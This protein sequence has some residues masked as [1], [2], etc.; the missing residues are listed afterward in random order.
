VWFLTEPG[1]LTSERDAIERLAT[2]VEWL[3]D[4]DWSFDSR[5]RLRLTF[6]IAVS[7]DRYALQMVYPDFFPFTPPDISPVDP[8]SRL[9]AHQYSDG[10]LCL[11]YR[12]DN[13]QS[14]ISGADMIRSS[15][16]LISIERPGG[17]GGQQVAS[18]HRVTLGQELRSKSTRFLIAADLR[19]F[20][21]T[22]SE[23]DSAYVEIQLTFQRE[24]TSAI[25]TKVMLPD[26]S[27]WSSKS[28]PTAVVT[29]R[30]V[31]VRVGKQQF[32][33]AASPSEARDLLNKAAEKLQLGTESEGRE[34]F[35][36]TDGENIRL[37]WQI[38]ANKDTLLNFSNLDIDEQSGERLDSSYG[39]L[40]MKSVAIVGC[41]SA[42]SKIAVS[43]ARS[44]VG[45]FVLIDDDVLVRGNL[46]RND[47]DWRSIGEHKVDGVAE[48]IRM[49]RPVARTRVRR[50]H[51][52]GQEA[53]ASAASVLSQIA[54]CDLIVDAT[55]QPE[56][57]N[58]LSS[59]AVAAAKSMVWLEVFAGG[60]GGFVA[61]HRGGVDE[62]PQAMRGAFLSWCRNKEAPWLQG[63]G[64]SYEAARP[65]EER[66][67]IADDGDVSVI[68]AH[69]ARMA[70]DV[71]L[72]ES[73]F[74]HSMYVMGLKKGWIFEE[75][76]ETYPVDI[77]KGSVVGAEPNSDGFA[78][79]EGIAFV[80][81]LLGRMRDEAPSA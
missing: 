4:L 11:E 55:A 27:I 33:G 12:P 38:G 69:A 37:M 57:F 13:W 9:S 53:A 18:A 80:M 63:T 74:P 2:E 17:P 34:F 44:G 71:L 40:S 10:G 5:G 72:G 60:I 62:T 70:V 15:H 61:R 29:Y 14:H 66:P 39:S 6:V 75:P 42:G 77:E 26:G 54:E 25:V 28:T 51:L 1:R 35:V 68:A 32:E 64:A 20:V 48:R 67:L 81:K 22:I 30:G 41:G 50:L 76:F 19:E 79:R 56:V 58:L 47:L 16:R 52:S 24:C 45:N 46:V 8:D 36:V 59:V 43:L 21:T 3:S 49:M 73:K 78:A 23:G 31:L 65:D 7:E